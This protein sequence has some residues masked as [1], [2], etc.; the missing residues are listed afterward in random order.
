MSTSPSA[1]LLPKPDIQAFAPTFTSKKADPNVGHRYIIFKK[2]I[3]AS[4][5]VFPSCLL[6]AAVM[7]C[8]GKKGYAA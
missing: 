4:S 5:T 1:G 2:A 3:L 8:V 6:Y 7:L